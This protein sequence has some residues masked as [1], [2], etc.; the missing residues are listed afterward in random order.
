MGLIARFMEDTYKGN[1]YFAYFYKEELKLL[2]ELYITGIME[3]VV[4]G[5][6]HCTEDKRDSWIQPYKICC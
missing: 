2:L 3:L 6:N 5:K 4:R 1:D